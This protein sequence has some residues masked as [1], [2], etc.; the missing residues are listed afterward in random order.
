M[1]QIVKDWCD[2]YEDNRT[3]GV[4]HQNRHKDNS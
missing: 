1:R 4:P 2:Y 3:C